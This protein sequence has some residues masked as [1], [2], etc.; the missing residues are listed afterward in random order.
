MKYSKVI[1]ALKKTEPILDNAEEL[2]DRIMRK[3]EQMPIGVRKNRIIR[4]F[5]TISGAAASIL[6]CLFA[7]ETFKFSTP[8]MVNH[9]EREFLQ[10][11][12]LPKQSSQEITELTILEKE[13]I[14]KT[15]IKRK[16]AQRMRK[17]HFKITLS[18]L[19]IQKNI[20]ELFK[21]K[22]NESM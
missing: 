13:N 4:I 3:V 8:S 12:F 21:K 5:G 18:S 20:V 9:S 22:N 6:I 7:Y 17:E 1:N 14:I 15:E 2:T 11:T 16:E 10:I 19:T